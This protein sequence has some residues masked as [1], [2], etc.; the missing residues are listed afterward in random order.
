MSEVPKVH[1]NYNT[2]LTHVMMYMLMHG[3]YTHIASALD[4]IEAHITTHNPIH[5]VY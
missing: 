1:D 4:C 3:K 2:N 5:N